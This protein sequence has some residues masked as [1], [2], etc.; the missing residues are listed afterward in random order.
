MTTFQA[1]LYAIIHGFSDFLPVSATAHHKLVAYLVG[2]PEP[3]GPMIGALSL[4]SL[5][6]LLVYFRHD[7]ASMISCFLQVILFRK[8]PM[9]LDERLPL[10][11]TLS[12]LPA[13]AGWYYFGDSVEQM[14]WT[15]L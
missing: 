8:K 14:A 12:T 2:W 15:P 5:L 11:L 10:F 7:W 13:V 1:I 4:G 3:A 9:T 6:A